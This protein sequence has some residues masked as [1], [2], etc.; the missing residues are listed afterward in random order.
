MCH[1]TWQKLSKR[2]IYSHIPHHDEDYAVEVG[3]RMLTLRHMVTENNGK[4]A[5]ATEQRDMIEFYA[6][7]IAH[8]LKD[9]QLAIQTL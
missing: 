2:G 8:H 5:L 9:E 6:N 7:T 1:F 3:L 4:F